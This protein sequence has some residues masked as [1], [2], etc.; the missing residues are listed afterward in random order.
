MASTGLFRTC[1]GA[2]FDDGDWTIYVETFHFADKSVAAGSAGT[3]QIRPDS[4]LLDAVDDL[5]IAQD[6][7]SIE[8]QHLNQPT[9]I[10]DWFL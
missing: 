1:E 6:P 7:S 9:G 3:G 10:F 8:L 4:S 5:P 2:G